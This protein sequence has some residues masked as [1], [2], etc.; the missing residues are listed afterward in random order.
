[1]SRPAQR[2]P[3]G[4]F[5]TTS[6]FSND[7]D[8]FI[9]DILNSIKLIFAWN[10][11]QGIR[12]WCLFFEINLFCNCIDRFKTSA[13]QFP[14]HSLQ[15]PFFQIFAALYTIV[16]NTFQVCFWISFTY[17]ESQETY[18]FEYITFWIVYWAVDKIETWMQVG[19]LLT[20]NGF[21]NRI[22]RKQDYKSWQRVNHHAWSLRKRL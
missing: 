10:G 14:S 7:R 3:V 21:R 9:P 1:M 13:K 20:A 2:R 16:I 4:R 5:T 12:I 22:C 19:A 11:C 17:S 6:G 18:L 8:C 15:P